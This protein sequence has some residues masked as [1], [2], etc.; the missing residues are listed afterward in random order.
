MPPP[1]TLNPVVDIAIDS[2]GYIWTSIYVGYLAEGA[3]A[4]WDG[5]VWKDF[6]VLDGLVG[7]NVKG[8]AIDSEDNIWVATS[9]GV[10]KISNILSVIN[11][12]ET[13]GFRI[14]PNPS[15]DMVYLSNEGK[16]IQ[17][18]SICNNL[19]TLIYTNNKLQEE[20]NIDISSFA[21][22]LYFVSIECENEIIT[23][24]VIIN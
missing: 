19:G 17:E 12:T 14:F 13:F 11:E 21:K 5:S 18:V 23:Q 1:D 15:N 2:W 22:G 24:K 3:V 7:P 6:D 16:T 20:Y 10:S 9:T 8:L 4:Y